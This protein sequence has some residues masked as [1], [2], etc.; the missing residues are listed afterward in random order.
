[1]INKDYKITKFKNK[2]S[3][4][5]LVNLKVLIKLSIIL[6]PPPFFKTIKFLNIDNQQKAFIPVSSLDLVKNEKL[7]TD[8]TI[9]VFVRNSF[10][11]RI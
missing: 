7:I 10:K 8:K 3:K 9:N 4:V 6:N 11:E 2:R 1:M 5:K